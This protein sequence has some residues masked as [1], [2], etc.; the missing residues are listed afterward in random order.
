MFGSLSLDLSLLNLSILSSA[1]YGHH[2]EILKSLLTWHC[3]YV[4][5]ISNYG[6]TQ[7]L[8]FIPLYQFHK[9]VQ[10]LVISFIPVGIWNWISLWLLL[11]WNA[12]I[13]STSFDIWSLIQVLCDQAASHWG[14]YLWKKTQSRVLGA[15]HSQLLAL[16]LIKGGIIID[17][18]NLSPV[19]TV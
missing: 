13:I 11:H 14:F 3:R 16:W 4:Y 17:P 2:L 9:T 1:W 5:C 18:P 8:F 15:S 19:R 6:A 7:K 12:W 10:K